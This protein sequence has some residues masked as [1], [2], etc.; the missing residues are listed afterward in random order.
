MG[1]EQSKIEYEGKQLLAKET[2]KFLKNAVEP[3]QKI[4]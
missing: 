2:E 4:M 3:E 1:F